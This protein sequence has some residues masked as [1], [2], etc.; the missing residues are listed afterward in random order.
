MS[1]G[2]AA[3]TLEEHDALV[4]STCSKAEKANITLNYDKCK[5]RRTSITFLGEKISERGIEPDP[6]KVEAIREWEKPTDVQSLQSFFGM[7]NFVGKFIP[8]LSARTTSLRS[9]LR[10]G[11]V[12]IW[13]TNHDQE[14]EDMR[15]ALTTNPVL[16]FYDPKKNHKVSGDASK[17]GIGN[18]LLQLEDDGWHPVHYAARSLTKQEQTYAPIE[19]EALAILHG[20]RKFHQYIFGK[21]FFIETDHHPLVSIFGGYLNDASARIQCI[22]L[23]ILKYDYTIQWVPRKFIVLADS[24]SKNVFIINCH[25]CGHCKNDEKKLFPIKFLLLNIF[26]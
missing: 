13:D 24:L 22:M 2:H 3:S 9:L 5:F 17:N 6:E 23:K 18:V 19:R 7:I 10:K 21:H 15:E 16:V 1:H 12:W 14:F 20:V 4:D 25:H 8:N 11:T 26:P